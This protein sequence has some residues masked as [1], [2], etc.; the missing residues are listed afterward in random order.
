MG[1]RIHKV[2]GYALTDLK[3]K[4]YEIT[5]KRINLEKLHNFLENIKFDRTELLKFAENNNYN[6]NDLVIGLKLFHSDSELNEKYN[7]F[8]VIKHD[9]EFGLKN[10]FL[11]TIPWCKDWNRYDDIIDYHESNSKNSIKSIWGNIYPYGTGDWIN[12]KT[13]QIFKH[14]EFDPSLI[15]EYLYGKVKLKLSEYLIKKHG[16]NKKAELKKIL[17]PVPPVIIK[18]LCEYIGLFNDINTYYELKPIIY[19]YWA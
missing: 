6:K 14:D 15:H 17:N 4:N 13:K 18:L 2:L 19:T 11:L 8:D 12:L 5:D 7:G 16:T 3:T 1:I 9:S 10:I